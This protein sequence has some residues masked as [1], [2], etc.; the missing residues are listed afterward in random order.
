MR[1]LLTDLYHATILSWGEPADD[2]DL[3][4]A[5]VSGRLFVADSPHLL[6]RAVVADAVGR[7]PASHPLRLAA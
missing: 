1:A 7:P 5:T 3:Y 4:V 6:L 2:G